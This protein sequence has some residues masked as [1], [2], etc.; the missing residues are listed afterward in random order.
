MTR[1]LKLFWEQ[2]I[3]LVC[4]HTKYILFIHLKWIIEELVNEQ[5]ENNE[6]L[7]GEDKISIFPIVTEITQKPTFTRF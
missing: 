2:P 4:V 1:F 7:C 6:W 5:Y 3:T